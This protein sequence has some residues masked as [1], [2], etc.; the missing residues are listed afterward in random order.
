MTKNVINLVAFLTLVA[1]NVNINGEANVDAGGKERVIVERDDLLSGP[2]GLW[3]V[4]GRWEGA[5]FSGRCQLSIEAGVE[6]IDED[7]EWYKRFGNSGG[8][9]AKTVTLTK[10]IVLTVTNEEWLDYNFN[11]TQRANVTVVGEF[12]FSYKPQLCDL[13]VVGERMYVD[14]YAFSFETTR[15]E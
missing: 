3:D 4:A 10:P 9:E 1:C 5:T 13:T 12:E 7:V 2:C 14:C 15:K 11:I 8:P 6:V